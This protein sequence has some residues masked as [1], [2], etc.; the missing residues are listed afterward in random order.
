MRLAGQLQVIAKHAYFYYFKLML[1]LKSFQYS[2]ST[3]IYLKIIIHHTHEFI[4][5]DISWYF[6]CF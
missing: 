3:Q 6:I 1:A 4:N 2:Y 5:Q